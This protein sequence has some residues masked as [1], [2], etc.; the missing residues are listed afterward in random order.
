MKA[1]NSKTIPIR[2]QF[3]KNHVDVIRIRYY[4]KWRIFMY[5]QKLKDSTNVNLVT[6][7]YNSTERDEIE[8]NVYALHIV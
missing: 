7:S 1:S 5:A 6:A 2:G 8:V 3:V 4:T